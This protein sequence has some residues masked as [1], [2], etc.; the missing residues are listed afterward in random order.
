MAMKRLTAFL[1]IAFLFASSSAYADKYTGTIK[2]FK[3]AG[4]SRWFFH[5]SYAYAVFPMVGEGGFIV[6]AAI[7]KGRVLTNRR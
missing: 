1:A 6:G 7:G 3:Q 2:T 4:E 5:H